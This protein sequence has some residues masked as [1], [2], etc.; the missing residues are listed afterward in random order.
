[1]AQKWFKV[2][3]I[4]NASD[5]VMKPLRAQIEKISSPDERAQGDELGSSFRPDYEF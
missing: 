3:S 1:M 5:R 4:S 2:L